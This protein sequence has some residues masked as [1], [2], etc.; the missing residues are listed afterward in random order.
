MSLSSPPELQFDRVEYV[1]DDAATLVC[2]VCTQPVDATYFEVNGQPACSVCASELE[3]AHPG[4]S[5][6]RGLGLSILAGVGAGILGALLYY[7]VLAMTGYEIGL[8]AIAVGWMVGHAVRWG[9]GRRGGRPYQVLAVVLTYVAIVSTYVPFVLAAAQESTP[10][11]STA[12]AGDAQVPSAVASPTP[13]GASTSPQP[14]ADAGPGAPTGAEMMMA[15]GWFTVIVLAL[16]FL[17][18]FQNIIGLLIIGIALFEAWKA[19]RLV[20]IEVAGPFTREG[21]APAVLSSP[22][23]R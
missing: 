9:S 19:N 11:T 17:A 15:L 13:T 23:A 4:S 5:L 7:A 16:P 1:D 20:A 8:I 14:S 21:G 22:D 18:G 6:L 3:R 10:V 2:G 12:P